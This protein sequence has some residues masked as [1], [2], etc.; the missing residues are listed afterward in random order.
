MAIGRELKTQQDIEEHARP[1]AKAKNEYRKELSVV[2][3]AQK[4]AAIRHNNLFE[5]NTGQSI[6]SSR[7]W[8]A[9]MQKAKR[10]RGQSRGM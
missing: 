9:G 4:S 10:H 8:A 6:R 2:M 5:E 7:R 3:E 1:V